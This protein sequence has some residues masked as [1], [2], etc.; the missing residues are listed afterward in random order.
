MFKLIAKSPSMDPDCWKKIQSGDVAAFSSLFKNHY[1]PLYQ[2]AGRYVKDAQT[3]ENIVQNVFVDLWIKKEKLEIKIS[4]KSYLYQM[5]RNQA[6]NILNHDQ[7]TVSIE[8]ESSLQEEITISPEDKFE[9]EEFAAIVYRAI[10]K[11]PA[12]CRQVY[13]MKRYDHF[14]YTEIAE[15]LAISVNTVKTQMTRALKSLQ[16]QLRNS[17]K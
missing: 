16:E 1:P 6:L 11:L 8:N 13:L 3:A 7:R 15:I 5:V 10:N 9:V 14:K 12:Q 4:L 2:F 17:I